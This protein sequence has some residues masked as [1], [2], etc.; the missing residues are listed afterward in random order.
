MGLLVNGVWRDQW[1]DTDSTGGE[2]V[3]ESAKLRD[4]VTADG[5]LGPQGVP[6]YRLR[7]IDTTCTFRW[8]VPGRIAP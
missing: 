8:P 4:W 3:R 5:S 1:Y 7:R 2:F 6:G